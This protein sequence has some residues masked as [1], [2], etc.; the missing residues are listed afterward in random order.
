MTTERSGDVAV[1]MPPALIETILGCLLHDVGK[2]VQRAQLGYSGRHSTIGRAFMKKVWLKD[3]RNPS[4]FGVEDGESEL[5]SD[6]RVIL[7]AI[8]YHHAGPLRAAAEHGRLPADAPAYIAYIAD[9]IAAGADRRKADSDGEGSERGVSTWDRDTPLFSVFNRFGTDRGDLRFRPEMLDDRAPINMPN[10]TEFEFG[11]YR[12]TEIVTKLVETLSGLE[13]SSQFVTSLLNVLEATLSYVPSSTDSSEVVDVSLFDHLRLSGAIGSCIWHYLKDS[14]VTDFK[15]ALLD[16]ET[17]FYGQEAFLLVTID[18]TGIQDFIYTIHTSGAAKM[19]RARSFY[20]ELL[21]EHLIDELLEAVGL[22][23]ANLNYSGGGHAYLLLPNTDAAR[24]AMGMFERDVNNWLIDRFRTGLFVSIGFVPFSARD[25]MRRTDETVAEAKA[26]AD[27]YSGLYREMSAQ[28]SAKK[29]ARYNADQIRK[30]NAAEMVGGREC[31]VCHT[32]DDTVEPVGYAGED[33][34][35]LCSICAALTRISPRILSTDLRFIIIEPATED[36]DGNLPLPF[37]KVLAMGDTQTAAAGVAHKAGARVYAKNKFYSGRDQGVHLWV[38]DYSHSPDFS[39]Y[40]QS[41]AGI[42]RLGIAR[43][44]VDN[45]GS[46]FTGGFN[47]QGSGAFNTISRTGTFSRML[48]L[49]FRQHINYLCEYPKYRPLTGCDSRQRAR[50]ITII[51]S[52]GDDVFV[53]GSWDDVFEFAVELRDKFQ[54]YTQG[55]LTL[56]AG[57]GMFP[58]KYPISVMARK[59]GELEDAAKECQHP[60]G[61]IKD[62][63]AVFESAMTFGWDRL[64][65][66]VIDEKYRC[67]AEFFE[68]DDEVGKTFVYTLLALLAERSE[69]ITLARWVY[70]LSRM[71]T[72]H[73]G[74]EDLF[75]AFTNQ[76]HQWFRDDQEAKELTMAL[77]LYVYRERNTATESSV[78]S[79]TPIK[80]TTTTEGGG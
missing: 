62:A 9:N 2:P 52:G 8:S 47:A 78:S 66:A 40:A 39:D 58:D 46:A 19:L 31:V 35:H 28:I 41:A 50:R 57:V 76:L 77:R 80:I 13:R 15:T 25:V 51:Y 67:V 33:K 48:S 68:G 42:K 64:R 43:M 36:N 63:V 12:Y 53:V 7:D 11:K 59:T 3:C 16:R 49:F 70:F 23:R 38:G 21:T 32:V 72:L 75:R 71:E 54:A 69:Q 18:I 1:A 5:D 34:P 56:S 79:E 27:R 30:L 22:S 65:T 24:A 4:E 44:D 10:E 73:R 17:D 60:D 6:D 26:R 20:L 29:L 55:K 74:D 37:D 61:S 14:G 45:L